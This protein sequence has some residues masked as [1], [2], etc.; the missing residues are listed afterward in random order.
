M[1]R[2]GN[3]TVAK[4]DGFVETEALLHGSKAKSLQYSEVIFFPG[5]SIIPIYF[6]LVGDEWFDP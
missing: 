1:A 6:V 4:M 2:S 3:F 5:L